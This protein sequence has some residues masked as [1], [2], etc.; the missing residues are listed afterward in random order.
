MS[1]HV[2]SV[3]VLGRGEVHD[4]SLLLCQSFVYCSNGA[5][6]D[7]HELHAAREES[8]VLDVLLGTF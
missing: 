1:L 8:R 5:V 3:F 7:A 6:D 4:A 2:D